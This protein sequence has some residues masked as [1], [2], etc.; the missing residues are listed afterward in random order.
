MQ[1]NVR[2]DRRLDKSPNGEI[3]AINF[4]EVS[5]VFCLHDEYSKRREIRRLNREWSKK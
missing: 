4:K 5:D 1:L 2:L 3:V